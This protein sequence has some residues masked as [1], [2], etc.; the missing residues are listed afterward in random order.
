[1]IKVVGPT[2]SREYEAALKLSELIAQSWPQVQESTEDSIYIIAAAKC[3]GQ[4]VRDI[5]L[6]LLAG[7]QPGYSY[8]PFLS[9]T[10]RSGQPIRPPSIEV[11]SL[12]AI[13]ELKDHPPEKVEFN[14]TLVD[15]F[16]GP[17]RKNASE[18][19]EKQLHSFLNYLKTQGIAKLPLV[20]PLIWLSN[21]ANTELPRR[22]HNIIG[23][24]LTWELLLNVIGQNSRVNWI[25]GHWTLD[26]VGGGSLAR[27]SDIFAKQVRP[28]RLDR[29]RMERLNQHSAELAEFN[30]IIGRKLLV[31]RGRGGTGK[32]MR[33]LQLATHLLDQQDARVL[34][35]TYNKALVADIRRMLTIMNIG[36]SLAAS[37]IQIQT[38]HSFLY[39]VI[40]ALDL[41][42]AGY[43]DFIANY[44]S[45]KDEALAYLGSGTISLADLA[46]KAT[47]GDEPFAWDY[48]FVDEGQ[49]WPANERDLLLRLYPPAQVAVAYGR[50]QLV[51]GRTA[52]SWRE[53]AAHGQSEVAMLKKTFR[54]KTGL[55]RFVSSVARHLGVQ[56][57]DWEANEELPG[58]QVI[59]VDGPYLYDRQLHD[60]LVTRNSEDQ[61]SPVDMLFCVPP[62]L[63]VHSPE[64]AERRSVAA[65][66]FT[67]WGYK[68]W[69]GAAEDV[70]ESYPTELEQ[71]RIVQYESCRGLEGW[72]VVN[73]ALDRFFELKLLEAG[74]Q[75][76]ADK[77]HAATDAPPDGSAT[78]GVFSGDPLQLQGWAAQ[79]VLI[80]L[81][82][83]MDTLVIQLDGRYST[84]RAALTAAA[85]ELPD[86]V[87]WRTTSGV[88]GQQS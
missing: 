57:A 75:P 28:T 62:S 2:D 73:L 24:A 33:L 78:P 65:T 43:T 61:N 88:S 54:M 67:Q 1:M 60:T 59:I 3:H 79:W 20:T 34:V 27:L 32:T 50:E 36:D 83:A 51:R 41:F 48:V 37:S 25:N 81:T 53:G 29:L 70:R 76:A 35:L 11:L 87:T 23:S 85:A 71:L 14:G 69:D 49:D 47:A 8:A 26:P 40:R 77:A 68:T 74:M 10:D 38:V 39:G 72:V 9:V 46:A 63:V 55:A 86:V 44:E 7:L 13:I 66:V 16:Y 82:R 21:V 19:V 22:P 30:A 64:S 18:Q 56:N 80:A 31:L 84:L 4:G 42:A 17:Q 52:T 58:G 5:D 45:L 15:V 6:L 12:C